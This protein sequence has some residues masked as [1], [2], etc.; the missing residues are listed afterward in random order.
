MEN[1]YDN[2]LLKYEKDQL[3][4]SERFEL[5]KMALDD[6]FLFESLEGYAYNQSNLEKAKRRFL[7]TINKNRE[8]ALV[9]KLVPYRW[10]A[11]VAASILLLS[12]LVYVFQDSDSLPEEFGSQTMAANEISPTQE[13]QDPANE[14]VTTNDLNSNKELAQSDDL[15]KKS[16]IINEPSSSKQLPNDPELK[17]NTG[18]GSGRNALASGKA[19]DIPQLSDELNDKSTKT[20]IPEP[21]NKAF[22][23]NKKNYLNQNKQAPAITMELAKESAINLK[24]EM[25]EPEVSTELSSFLAKEIAKHASLDTLNTAMSLILEIN[26]DSTIQ[27]VIFINGCQLCYDVLSDQLINKKLEKVNPL[28]VGKRLIFQYKSK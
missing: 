24:E 21:E 10:I 12:G 7:T 8:N 27:N 2:I 15:G 5:E 6:D 28:Q 13:S 26:S 4:L 16:E 19:V 1:K 18:Q 23:I 3:S 25:L 20:D 9:K 22:S 11:G 14:I 17:L